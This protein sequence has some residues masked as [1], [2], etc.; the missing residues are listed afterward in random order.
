MLSTPLPSYPLHLLLAPN[1]ALGRTA[2]E[3]RETD[4][5]RA[6]AMQPANAR[7]TAT[8][9]TTTADRGAPPRR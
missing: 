3:S 4:R 6:S 2:V 9:A 8:A 7:G 1:R 5:K